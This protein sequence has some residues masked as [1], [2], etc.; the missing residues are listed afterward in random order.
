METPNLDKLA[1]VFTALGGDNLD[2]SRQRSSVDDGFF[3]TVTRRDDAGFWIGQGD[4]V[5]EAISRMSL[6]K[7]IDAAE[8]SAAE[9]AAA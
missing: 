7:P 1:A 2:I 9:S 4:S 6:N 5:G 3:F 8:V